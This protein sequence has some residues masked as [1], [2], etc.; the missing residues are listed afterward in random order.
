ML[1]YL[2]SRLAWAVPIVLAIVVINFLII[3]IVPGDPIQALVGD[4]PA[5]PG[6]AEQ[7]RKEFGLDQPILV[8]LGLY[9]QN[10]AVGNLGF[11]FANRQPVLGLILDRAMITL[12]LMIPALT[13]A[14][15]T[16]IVLALAAA[17]RA[18]SLYDSGIT[19]ISLVGYSVP[20]FWLGQILVIVFA[21]KLQ[22]LPAQGM[23]TL[24]EQLTGL[25]KFTDIVW[26]LVLPCFSVTIYYLAVV[27]R[28]TRAS[29]LEAMSQDFVLT[30]RAKGLNRRSV[31][32]RHILPNALIPVATVIGYNFGNS[33]TGAIMVETVFAW[34][35][36]GQL[37]IT[38]IGN[39]DYPVLQG[40]FL[41]TAIT[42]VLVNVATDMMYALLDPRVRKSYGTGA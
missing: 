36:L 25:A 17:P 20:I 13:M 18:G 3:H 27:A 6:Y 23:I 32:W 7:V 22:W 24:R 35:G 39:R 1:R 5:P 11:S 29:V 12:M 8:Q 30:A 33:L 40:I 42:V 21:I 2:L 37:F 9:L 16:G 19:A 31:L 10:L 28:V 41:F 4:F 26:H 15:I 14:A 34:P 38:S